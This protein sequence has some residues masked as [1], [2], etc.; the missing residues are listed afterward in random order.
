M[1]VCSACLSN[2]KNCHVFNVQQVVLE[3]SRGRCGYL[4]SVPQSFN[5]SFPVAKNLLLK[6]EEFSDQFKNAAFF[7]ILR[8]EV[9]RTSYRRNEFMKLFLYLFR[10]AMFRLF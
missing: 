10:I 4:L 8:V 6:L 3:N 2:K 5:K 9:T 1:F 7:L